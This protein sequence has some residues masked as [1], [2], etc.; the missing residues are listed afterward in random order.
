MHI[1][2]GQTAHVNLT[3]HPRDLSY[4][5]DAGERVIAPGSYTLSVGGGQPSTE[6]PAVEARFTITGEKRLPE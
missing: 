5:T 2:A 3:I 6:A 1:A 4:V